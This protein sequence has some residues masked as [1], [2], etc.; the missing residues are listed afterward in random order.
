MAKPNRTCFCCGKPYHYCPH[1]PEYDGSPSYMNTWCSERCAV[2]FETL[3]DYLA[4][5]IDEKEA[6]KN[7]ERFDFSDVDAWDNKDNAFEIK[8]LI[9]INTKKAEDVSKEVSKV[10]EVDEVSVSSVTDSF[11]KVFGKKKK[12]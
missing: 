9:E 3:S 12:S 1:C 8:D 5:R 7:I 2:T 4:G 6:Y 11:K 10:S